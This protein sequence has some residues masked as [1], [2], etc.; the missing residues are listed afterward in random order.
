MTQMDGRMAKDLT[1]AERDTWLREHARKSR[2]A[3]LAEPPP[4]PYHQPKMAR[5]M[6]E[7]ER[8]AWFA[9]HKRRYR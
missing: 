3:T 5:D 1:E 7:S 8:A 4:P 9:E 6:T 2:D